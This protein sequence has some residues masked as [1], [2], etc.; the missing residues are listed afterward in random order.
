M[1]MRPREGSSQGSRWKGEDERE[2]RHSR[3][4]SIVAVDAAAA[5]KISG[6]EIREPQQEKELLDSTL[7]ASRTKFSHEAFLSL[8]SVHD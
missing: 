2:T 8:A 5:L 1:S 4:S 7:V 3:W 6:Q